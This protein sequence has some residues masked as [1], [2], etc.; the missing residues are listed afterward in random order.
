MVLGDGLLQLDE[1]ALK[2][3]AAHTRLTMV[4]AAGRG[5]NDNAP[6]EAGALVDRP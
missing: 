5:Q 6:T 4:L 2:A 1:E 3:D